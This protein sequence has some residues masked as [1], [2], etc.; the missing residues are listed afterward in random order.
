[1]GLT[2]ATIK[3]SNPVYPNLSS[4]EVKALVDTGAATLCVPEHVA[5]QLNLEEIDKREA[6]TA[7]G[8]KHLIPYAG[9]VKIQ[10]KN[11]TCFTGAFVLGDEILM[12]AVPME[13]MDLVI[14]PL[15][16]TIDVNPES[17]NIPSVLIK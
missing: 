13:D 12:G 11:R 14:V 6:T 7:D 16:Q 8:R 2:H 4:M 9:P 3:L 10:F 15:K 5:L 17:P 1:M